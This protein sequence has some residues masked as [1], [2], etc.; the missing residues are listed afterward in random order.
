MERV[1]RLAGV[2]FLMRKAAGAATP[3]VEVIKTG[4]QSYTLKTTSPLKSSEVSFELGKPV[5][6][7]TL[8]GREVQVRV[9]DIK[10][11]GSNHFCLLN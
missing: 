8:D 4:D 7:T 9:R 2:G 10:R 5:P 3:V 6:E 1:I 11:N